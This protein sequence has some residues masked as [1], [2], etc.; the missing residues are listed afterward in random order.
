LIGCGV[1]ADDELGG[2]S[3]TGWGESI[4][5]VV[6][7]KYAVDAL[8]GGRDPNDVASKAIEYLA[9]RVG[10]SGGIILADKAGRVGFSFNTP[11]MARA[12]IMEGMDG[13]RSWC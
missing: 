1:Y 2:A 8:E 13:V 10:G 9:R 5:R 7:S 12:L 6:L 4:T 3:T 11:H